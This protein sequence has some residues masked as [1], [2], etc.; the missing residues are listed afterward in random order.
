MEA[1]NKTQNLYVPPSPIIPKERARNPYYDNNAYE[2]EDLRNNSNIAD[3][4]ARAG[5][6]RKPYQQ[7]AIPVPPPLTP[8]LTYNSYINRR[9][10]NP[11]RLNNSNEE[12][13][14]MFEY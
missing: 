11:D 8:N 12:N 9:F 4:S 10:A 5:N 7:N 14:D 6:Y 13:F 1:Y 3:V 2:D